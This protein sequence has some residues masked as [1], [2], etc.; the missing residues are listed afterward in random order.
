[1]E[2]VRIS[3]SKRQRQR[4]F[5]KMRLGKGKKEYKVAAQS[6]FR[7]ILEHVRGNVDTGCC[8]QMMRKGLIAIKD[9]S[10]EDNE[11][12]REEENSSEWT[13]E[14]IREAYETL[15]RDEV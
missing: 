13:L 5:W 14:K 4:R 8:P 9:G 10:W 15:A 7:E 1:M 2:C 6:P 11:G 3:L 12:C